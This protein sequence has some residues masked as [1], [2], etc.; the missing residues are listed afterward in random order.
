MLNTSII[1]FA[2]ATGCIV[3]LLVLNNR[4]KKSLKKNKSFHKMVK[5]LPIV[6]YLKD[7]NGNIISATEELA[8]ITGFSH[9]ELVTKNFKD[10]YPERFW[11]TIKEQDLQII[12]TKQSIDFEKPIDIIENTVHW[13]QVI[14]S[15]VFDSQNNVIGITVFYKNIDKEKEIEECKSTF[16]ATLTH[17]LKTPINAQNNMLSLLYEGS[18]GELNA[19]QKE[20]IRLTSCSNKYMADIVFT[21]L[22]TYQYENGFFNL[23]YETFNII[24]L[25]NSL[26]KGAEGLANEKNLTIQFSHAATTI[27][28]IYADRF[29]IK[30]VIMNFLSNAITYG[31]KNTTINIY[32]TVCKDNLELSITNISKQIPPNELDVI[33]E[34][35]KKTAISNFNKASTGLG[36]YLSKE[37]INMHGGEIFAKSFEDGTC[38]FGFV[39]PLKVKSNAEIL[40]EARA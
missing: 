10:I 19:E 28:D 4:L 34:K 40:E 21:I 15:P 17:D 3:Y 2:A 35:F 24:E 20:M 23:H 6:L 5:S 25:I 12:K 7:L 38:V 13:Y 26:C 37:I 8:K 11:N 32:L 1:F 18:F 29:Q 16:M 22:D 36:L 39:L 9:E 30:R 33:F 27:A 14:K 31:F